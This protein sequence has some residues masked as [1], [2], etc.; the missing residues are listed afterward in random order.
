LAMKERRFA[1]GAVCGMYSGVHAICFS[2][3]TCLDG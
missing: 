3:S 1:S 2:S